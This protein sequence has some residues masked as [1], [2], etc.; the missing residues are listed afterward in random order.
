[1]PKKGYYIA[2]KVN[3]ER[4]A[5]RQAL[6]EIDGNG[7]KRQ[8]RGSQTTYACVGCENNYC[9]QKEDCFEALHS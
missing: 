7:N 9:C 6:G 8:K 5:K 1:M 3:K 4:P 2:Y